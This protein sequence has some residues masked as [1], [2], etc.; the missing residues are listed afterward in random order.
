MVK[1]QI[2]LDF[3]CNDTDR[4]YRYGPNQHYTDVIEDGR[5]QYIIG[6]D[7]I[8]PDPPTKRVAVMYEVYGKDGCRYPVNVSVVKRP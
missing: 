7:D 1:Q 3:I 5:L 8:I 6:T 2:I 4:E